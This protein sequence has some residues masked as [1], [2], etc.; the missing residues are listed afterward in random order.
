[1]AA[2]VRN[3]VAIDPDRFATPDVPEFGKVH[4]DPEL[5]RAF[6]AAP[7]RE[8][9]GTCPTLENEISS[10]GG[11]VVDQ[12]SGAVISRGLYAVSRHK[13]GLP[14]VSAS[15]SQ[16]LVAVDATLGGEAGS[17][18]LQL[19]AKDAAGRWIQTGW[20]GFWIS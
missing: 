10:N 1:M 8:L 16:A 7:T 14:L 2:A 15:G 6:V 18:G 20:W 19:W 3:G 11:R 13:I 4:A 17:G 5:V 9:L 12:P